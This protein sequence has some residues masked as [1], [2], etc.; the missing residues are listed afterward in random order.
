MKRHLVNIKIA[1]V[2]KGLFAPVPMPSPPTQ[3][4]IMFPRKLTYFNFKNANFR[5][6]CDY[7]LRHS[8]IPCLMTRNYLKL[9]KENANMPHK[10][11]DFAIQTKNTDLLAIAEKACG[12]YD[13]VLSIEL[14]RRYQEFKS[15]ITQSIGRPNLT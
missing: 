4:Q 3:D 9:S 5:T 12:L 14:R 7:I 6:I 15:E 11:L 1:R 2:K 8:E 10:L 13:A